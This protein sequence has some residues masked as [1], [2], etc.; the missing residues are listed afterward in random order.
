MRESMA[1]TPVQSVHSTDSIDRGNIPQNGVLPQSH[2]QNG[3]Q[4]RT[5]NYACELR[6][7]LQ[8]CTGDIPVQK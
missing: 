1:P 5:K 6:A 4:L 3:T 8:K 7:L 2:M